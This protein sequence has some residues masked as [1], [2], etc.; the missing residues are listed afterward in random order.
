MSHEFSDITS[1]QGL[2]NRAMNEALV[3]EA[4]RV[5]YGAANP[6]QKRDKIE[7]IIG[8]GTAAH[9]VPRLAQLYADVEAKREN[10][11]ASF[12]PEVVS[13]YERNKRAV[14]KKNDEKSKY[15]KPIDVTSK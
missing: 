13:Q 11:D 12:S 8:N 5:A 6:E 3:S 4:V 7:E 15:F 10:L 14:R 1:E 2:N 9:M